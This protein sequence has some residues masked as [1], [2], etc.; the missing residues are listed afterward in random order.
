MC[1]VRY[2]GLPGRLWACYSCQ[3]TSDTLLTDL[4]IHD[5]TIGQDILRCTNLG[6]LT[7]KKPREVGYMLFVGK[8]LGRPQMLFC[9]W[10]KRFAGPRSGLLFSHNHNLCAVFLTTSLA[11]ASWCTPL[12]CHS[13]LRN[14][15]IPHVVVCFSSVEKWQLFFASLCASLCA[16]YDSAD[17]LTEDTFVGLGG[18]TWTESTSWHFLKSE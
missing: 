3:F 4:H 17:D 9:V 2:E 5:S 7:E 18:H 14:Q 1:G 15:K 13:T 11:T 16:Q 12:G 10:I 8:G 6:S